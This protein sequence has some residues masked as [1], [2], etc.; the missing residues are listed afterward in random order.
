MVH[1]LSFLF[2]PLVLLLIEVA[3]L[4]FRANIWSRL[5]RWFIADPISATL[6]ILSIYC[7]VRLAIWAMR[8]FYAWRASKHLVPFKVILPRTDSKIDE[9]KRTE[10]DFKEKIAIMEQLFRALHEVKDLTFWDLLHFFV[11]RYKNISFELYLEH[12]Q[13][14]F[15][16]L[17]PESLTSI[18]EKQITSYYP[19]AEVARQSTPDVAPPGHKLV[20]YNMITKKDFS[21]P[22]RFFNQMQD[23]PLN[24]LTN[25]LSKLN[26]DEE[27][28]IQVIIN[29]TFTDRW[30]KKVKN[31]ASSRFKG[32]QET[33]FDRIPVLKWIGFIAGNVTSLGLS[34][35]NAPGAKS[36]DAFVRM[37]QPEE[38][39]YKRMG[40]KAGMSG[41]RSTIRIVAAAPSWQRAIDITNNMQVAF[42]VYKDDYG[43]YFKNRRFWVD[44]FPLG[45]NARIMHWLFVLE[46]NNL[47]SNLPSVLLKKSPVPRNPSNQS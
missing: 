31:F 2:W 9:E 45:W 16:V 6:T 35:T 39:L 36:G 41:F 42:N 14:T 13:I 7:V 18:V 38:E 17:M 23:D 3:N 30:S 34:E 4:I 24:D 19:N 1:L 33:I 44:F 40:E 22:I 10:K 8:F 47:V 32:K 15:Y 29:P 25:V 37:I 11:F 12:G 20:A 28:A 5:G 26:S 46:P 43:N 27:A 21:Y